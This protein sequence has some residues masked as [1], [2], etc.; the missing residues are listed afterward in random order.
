MCA[1]LKSRKVF[2][3]KCAKNAK[4]IATTHSVCTSPIIKYKPVNYRLVINCINISSYAFI[5]VVVFVTR[6][7]Q[8]QKFADHTRIM[9]LA[10]KFLAALDCIFSMKMLFMCYDFDAILSEIKF[11]SVLLYCTAKSINSHIFP[12]MWTNCSDW[13]QH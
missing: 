3:K 2:Q 13:Q 8:Q 4:I 12:R 10:S 6:Q 1:F 11:E 7:Q 9:H 5:F